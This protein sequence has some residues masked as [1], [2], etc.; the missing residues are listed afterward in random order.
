MYK[1]FVSGFYKTLINSEEAISMSTM[2]EIDRIRQDGIIFI[3]ASERDLGSV[4]EY[5]RD[6]PFLDY[7][8]CYNGA[9]IYDVGKN[10]VIYKKNIRISII[11]KI[12]QLFSKYKLYFYT[13]DKY[14]LFDSCGFDDCGFNEFVLEMQNDIYKIEV[15][16]SKSELDDVADKLK[17]EGVNINFWSRSDNGRYFVEIVMK[18]I[19]KFSAVE[20][21]CKKKKINMDEVVSC[22]SLITDLELVKNV[23]L[24]FAMRNGC[25]EVKKFAKKVTFSNENKGVENILKKYF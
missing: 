21:I 24:G 10:K 3:V 7:V 11:K 20:V 25:K 4:L 6:F 22:G 23:G 19:D 9:Y 18:N 5:N 8:I 2:V 1:L 13:S 15:E 12:K 16:C 14:Y 17:E